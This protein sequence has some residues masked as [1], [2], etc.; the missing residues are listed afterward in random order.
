[1]NINML[2]D[3]FWDINVSLT[4]FESKSSPGPY[5]YQLI[6]KQRNILELDSFEGSLCVKITI[7]PPSASPV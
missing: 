6:H 4:S 2:N 1:M 3:K 7:K 5:H